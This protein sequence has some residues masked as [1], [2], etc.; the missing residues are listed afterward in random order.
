MEA[1]AQRMQAGES[2]AFEAFAD[3]FGPRLL[4]FFVYRGLSA[5]DAESLAVSAVSDI[6]VKIDQFA[7][8]GP[9]SFSR[10][11]YRVADNALRD[12]LR[13]RRPGLL[14][15]AGALPAPPEGEEGEGEPEL[16]QAILTA[17]GEL[18]EPD[19]TIIRTRLEDP[20]RTFA[21]I[22]GQ[23]GLEEGTARVRYHRV[24]KKLAQRLEQQ[25]AV[26]AWQ[27]R[28]RAGRN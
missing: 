3:A 15:D 9:G 13:L 24:L 27:R 16:T 21:E 12:Q 26:R 23:V 7:P 8:R 18:T 2:A 4:R 19:R 20:D 14:A 1:V 17:V 5:A 6:A 10:W 25:P 28:L 22:G 11:V